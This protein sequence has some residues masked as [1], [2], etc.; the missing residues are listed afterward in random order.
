M[1]NSGM[2]HLLVALVLV[3][4]AA[5]PAAADAPPAPVLKLVTAG[6]G[7]LR[8]LRFKPT[9]GAKH[10][11]VMT[12]QEASVRGE[13]GK[14]PPLE[15]APAVRMTIELLVTDVAAGGDIRY[16]YV[17]RKVEVVE[18]KATNPD[19]VGQMNFMLGGLV[20]TTARI[21]QT[22]RGVVKESDITVAPTAGSAL[23]E[24]LEGVHSTLNQ[25]MQPLPEERLGVG[26][27]WNTTLTAKVGQVTLQQHASHELVEFD[28]TRGKIKVVLKQQGKDNLPGDLRTAATGTSEISF[29]LTRVLPTQ[30][31]LELRT[32]IELEKL[33]LHK[34]SVTTLTS[35]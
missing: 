27:R 14:L 20:G 17:Y 16:E 2:Q 32:E 3:L 24:N 31:R 26:A 13:R 18:D 28:G 8:P 12:T 22:S 33:A 23:R 9:K 25:V 35:R 19:V 30:A 34:T 10:T 6:K 5:R 7:A 4:A 29:D 1:Q 15:Q 21:V 11:I